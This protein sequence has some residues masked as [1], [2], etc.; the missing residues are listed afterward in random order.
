MKNKQTRIFLFFDWSINKEIISLYNL[1]VG[2]YAKQVLWTQYLKNSLTYE[3]DI[4][5]TV[6]LPYEDVLINFKVECTKYCQ[7][8]SPFCE[9]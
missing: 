7:I 6:Y 4:W 8:Y 5:Y 1:Y 3:A 2:G 9:N